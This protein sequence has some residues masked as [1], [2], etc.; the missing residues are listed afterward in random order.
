[1]SPN[2]RKE[3]QWETA[4]RIKTAIANEQA[5]LGHYTD[6][7]WNL[8]YFYEREIKRLES[9]LLVNN[10]SLA[11][12][13]KRERELREKVRIAIDKHAKLDIGWYKILEQLLGGE[14]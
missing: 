11:A 13:E 7:L 12:A 8:V 3:G 5:R 10:E 14:K 2:D 1:M 9:D 6:L 4:E